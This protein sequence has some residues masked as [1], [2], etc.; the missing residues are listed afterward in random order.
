MGEASRI[1]R[2]PSKTPAQRAPSRPSKSHASIANPGNLRMLTY[3]PSAMADDRAFVVGPSSAADKPRRDTTTAP[4][5]RPCAERY[6][7][8]LLLPEQQRSNNPNGCFNWFE[9]ADT[10]R[11]GGEAASIPGDGQENGARERDRPAPRVHHRSVGGRSHD[12]GHAGLLPARSLAGG[13]DHR[14]SASTARP[15]RAAS[16]PEHVSKSGAPGARVGRSDQA[17]CAQPQGS[18]AAHLGLA[19]RRGQDGD[20]FERARNSEAMDRGARGAVDAFTARPSST[21]TPAKS[22]LARPVRN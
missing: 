14:R 11:G 2:P 13:R 16:V 1:N 5:G 20:P 10:R 6:G 15:Q 9:P 7:F 22:G 19:G 12:V 4:D 18:M 3:M 8:A 21:V 17:G